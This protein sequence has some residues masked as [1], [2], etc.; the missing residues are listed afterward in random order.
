MNVYGGRSTVPDDV[1][2]WSNECDAA[3]EL[4]AGKLLILMP[5]MLHLMPM[6]SDALAVECGARH[7][8]PDRKTARCT[9]AVVC[10]WS[11][12]GCIWCRCHQMHWRLSRAREAAPDPGRSDALAR[13][14][15]M[16]DGCTRCWCIRCTGEIVWLPGCCTRPWSGQMHAGGCPLRKPVDQTSF[17]MKRRRLHPMS[18]PSGALA[19]LSVFSECWGSTVVC[20]RRRN[21]ADCASKMWCQKGCT[22]CWCIRCTGEVVCWCQVAAP[23]PERSNALTRLSV[24]RTA[25]D[26]D[27]IECTD[28]IVC[29][30]GGLRL[31]DCLIAKIRCD[32]NATSFAMKMFADAADWLTDWLIDCKTNFWLDDADWTSNVRFHWLR[33]IFFVH[34]HFFFVF[35]DV[36]RTV[37]AVFRW[38]DY[39]SCRTK[40]LFRMWWYINFR[41]NVSLKNSNLIVSSQ[42]TS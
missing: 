30:S 32:R 18:R 23:D 31:N 16:P 37:N 11:C 4:W 25:F 29:V 21:D 41:I 19:I 6:S 14:S 35:F 22:R 27:V 3:T 10:W 15:V 24:I 42:R 20:W 33:T 38:L 36:F 17:A 2:K 8:A 5:E 28:E 9:L 26:A 40:M 12:Q 39:F 13:L 34:R 1:R 7:A